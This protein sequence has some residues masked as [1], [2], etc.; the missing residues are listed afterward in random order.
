[1]QRTQKWKNFSIGAR[2]QGW[3]TKQ[4]INFNEQSE[5]VFDFSTLE[6]PLLAEDKGSFVGPNLTKGPIGPV[7]SITTRS[8]RDFFLFASR[9]VYVWHSSVC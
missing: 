4:T 1:M 6:V 8:T 7:H 3:R 5:S 9:S 2:A